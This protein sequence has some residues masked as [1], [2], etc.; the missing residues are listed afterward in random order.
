MPS[1]S[2]LLLELLNDTLV[3][4]GLAAGTVSK[5]DENIWSISMLAPVDGGLGLTG[6]CSFEAAA[7]DVV[8]IAG[9]KSSTLNLI[10]EYKTT[11]LGDFF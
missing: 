7:G 9:P 4:L 10:V 8:L 11:R 3:A 5:L 1:R 6:S 2:E